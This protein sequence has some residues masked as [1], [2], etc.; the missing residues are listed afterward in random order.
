MKK[1]QIVKLL[2]YW[3]KTEDNC[4][5]EVY[6]EIMA[7]DGDVYVVKHDCKYSGFTE[8]QLEAVIPYTVRVRYL[9][10]GLNKFYNYRVSKSSGLVV[11]DLI[12]PDGCSIAEVVELDTKCENAPSK[13]GAIYKPGEKF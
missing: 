3:V 4:L 1:G 9:T 8:S 10:S 13:V 5:G 11:G 7:K 12:K 6:G 2:G